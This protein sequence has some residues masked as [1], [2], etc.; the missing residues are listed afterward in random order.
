MLMPK[1]TK[2]RK[3][4]R[5][6]LEGTTKGGAYVAFGDYGLQ[7]LECSYITACQIEATR[8]GINRKMRKGGRLWIRIFPDVPITKKPLETRMGKGKGEIDHWAA[9]VRKGRILFELGGVPREVAEDAFRTAAHKLPIHVR[10]VCRDN[11][12]GE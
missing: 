9:A 10:L 3:P 1:R 5:V 4:H 2:Y 7:A 8:V 6:C 12:G 11:L